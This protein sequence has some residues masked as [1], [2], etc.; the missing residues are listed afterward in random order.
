[1]QSGTAHPLLP[2]SE[3]AEI[4]VPEAIIPSPYRIHV[5]VVSSDIIENVFGD[6][7]L[8]SAPQE[9]LCITNECFEVT[10]ALYLTPSEIRDSQVVQDRFER[11]LALN[12]VD[13]IEQ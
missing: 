8:R 6:A 2:D 11:I 5:Y 13:V 10:S 9:M 1:M 7:D 4:P 12:L 3:K